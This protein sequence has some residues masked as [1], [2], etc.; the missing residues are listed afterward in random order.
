MKKKQRRLQQK[1]TKAKSWFFEE[2]N[3]L[4]YTCLE[5]SMDRGAWQAAVQGV[6][7]SQTPLRD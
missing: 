4:Q 1:S 6:T 3:T 7:K 5:K 2:I